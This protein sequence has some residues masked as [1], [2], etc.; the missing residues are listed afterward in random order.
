L[1]SIAYLLASSRNIASL[2]TN[3]VRYH[4]QVRRYFRFLDSGVTTHVDEPGPGAELP[5]SLFVPARDADQQEQ[6][7]RV[8]V[9]EIVLFKSEIALST[10]SLGTLISRLLGNA[11]NQNEVLGR[12]KFVSGGFRFA[13]VSV[14][15][16]LCASQ[17][18]PE[19]ESKARSLC[20]ELG[21]SA[22]L[23]E[24]ANGYE[25][26]MNEQVWNAMDA[27]SRAAIR[28]VPLCI[29]KSPFIAII[30]VGTI[31][32]LGEKILPKL[33][34]E[35]SGSYLFLF[36]LDGATCPDYAV[37]HFMT[38]SAGDLPQIGDRDWFRQSVVTSIATGGAISVENLVAITDTEITE[39]VLM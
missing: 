22:C 29:D 18:T 10:L 8:N 25:T 33:R 24:L 3:L 39:T 13:K 1:G 16:Q 27:A 38:I 17:R 9:G 32:S 19:R 31:Q 26:T 4:P 2:L 37:D 36:A 30:D 6:T 20:E 12:I 15:E 11:A 7:V 28:L 34:A 14:M 21:A 5:L 23:G 35:F